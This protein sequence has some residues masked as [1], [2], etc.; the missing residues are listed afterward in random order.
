[1]NEPEKLHSL[2]QQILGNYPK[3]KNKNTSFLFDYLLKEVL[4]WVYGLTSAGSIPVS[5][6][7]TDC[8]RERELRDGVTTLGYGLFVGFIGS[9]NNIENKIR[10]RF[11]VILVG[12]CWGFWVK[13]AQY[14]LR[15]KLSPNECFMI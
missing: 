14:P 10:S 3:N 6:R 7:P 4:E 13:T 2:E 1:M 15:R 11:L 12:L 9:K 5:L 8:G